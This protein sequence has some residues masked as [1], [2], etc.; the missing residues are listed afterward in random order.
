M[1]LGCFIVFVVWCIHEAVKKQKISDEDVNDEGSYSYGE[2]CWEPSRSDPNEH[3]V[4]YTA[5][6]CS[7]CYKAVP[8]GV[9][10]L[11]LMEAWNRR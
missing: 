4:R 2:N 3:P 1:L 9:Q 11:I 10:A 6:V 8:E 5:A 7:L